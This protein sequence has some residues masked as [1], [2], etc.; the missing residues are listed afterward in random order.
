LG[1]Y[2][3]GSV[4]GEAQKM[5]KDFAEGLRREREREIAGLG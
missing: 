5:K 2:V 1:V 4:I 3:L